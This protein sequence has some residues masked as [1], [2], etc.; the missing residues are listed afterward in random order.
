MQRLWNLFICEGR[1]DWDPA[2][3]LF[4]N[5]LEDTVIE[6][7]G[8]DETQTENNEL[9]NIQLRREMAGAIKESININAFLER[10]RDSPD[11]EDK[12]AMVADKIHALTTDAVEWDERS[13][14]ER[15]NDNAILFEQI[16]D[17][18]IKSADLLDLEYFNMD[19]PNENVDNDITGYNRFKTYIQENFGSVAIF[20]SLVIAIVGL[21]TGL[22]IK[23]KDT[24][25]TVASAAYIGSEFLMKLAKTLGRIR[26]QFW[27]Y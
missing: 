16:R 17:L 15:R 24:I 9:E 19:K 2:A 10:V 1:L 11:I 7:E 26:N 13:K 22:I 4:T 5:T 27:K 21:I 3:D 14:S 25:R 8:T 23:S 20:S 6:R 18:E 12:D